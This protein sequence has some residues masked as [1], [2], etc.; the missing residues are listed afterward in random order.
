MCLN[1]LYLRQPSGDFVKVSCG[2]CAEC[3]KSQR[4]KWVVRIYNELMSASSPC[5]LVTLTYREDSVPLVIS[6]QTGEVGR[7]LDIC[8]VQSH[9]K[10]FRQYCR[11]VL[12]KSVEF[13][14]FLCGEYGANTHRPHYHV[15]LVNL[16]NRELVVYLKLWES[17]FGHADSRQISFDNSDSLC[18]VAN[19]VSKYVTKSKVSDYL[20][21]YEDERLQSKFRK[22]FCTSSQGFGLLCDYDKL[23]NLW[24]FTDTDNFDTW[25]TV[26]KGFQYFI[27]GIP[28][29]CP[30]S[31]VFKFFENEYQSINKQFNLSHSLLWWQQLYS[32]FAR[33]GYNN[34]VSKQ[35]HQIGVYEPYSENA[36]EVL[37]KTNREHASRTIESN[38]RVAAA[39]FRDNM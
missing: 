7:T 22:T 29:P 31:L 8:D 6:C 24:H 33:Q 15:I 17:Y 2:K 9:H 32:S 30:K 35:L 11:K 4:N 18:K 20:S 12:K 3:L 36:F 19:Y 10:R 39:I 26:F 34:L 37:A 28:Y 1:V 25:C 23:L 14:Y 5:Y 16:S 38:E 27:N 21:F 13:R